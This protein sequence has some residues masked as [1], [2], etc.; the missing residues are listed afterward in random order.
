M[1]PRKKNSKQIE[2]TLALGED[3]FLFFDLQ[4]IPVKYATEEKKDVI[5]NAFF[6]KKI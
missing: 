4:A 1:L 6:F 5:T 2:S 3:N